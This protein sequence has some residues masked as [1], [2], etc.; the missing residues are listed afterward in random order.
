MKWVK[1]VWLIEEPS[2]AF[3]PVGTCQLSPMEQRLLKAFL[4]LQHPNLPWKARHSHLVASSLTKCQHLA[5]DS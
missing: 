5:W 3:Q 4:L 2:R 1:G